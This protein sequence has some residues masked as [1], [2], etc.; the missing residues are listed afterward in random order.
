MDQKAALGLLQE[1][2]A[3]GSGVETGLINQDRVLGIVKAGGD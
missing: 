2:V 3:N 1:T